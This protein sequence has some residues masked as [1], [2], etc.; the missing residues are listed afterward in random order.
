MTDRERWT[1][2]PLL[3]LALGI[4]LKD[5]LSGSVATDRVECKA[6]VCEAVEVV[7]P[8]PGQRVTINAGNIIC[9]SLIATDETGKQ[10]LAAVSSNQDGGV[11]RTY[12]THTGTHA[13][14]GNFK[15]YAGLLFLDARGGGHAGPLFASPVPLQKQDAQPDAA[16][17][18][19]ATGK[20]DG[21]PST[22]AKAAD[23]PAEDAAATPEAQP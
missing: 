13:V 6:V 5:K 14:L 1:V 17:Q 3:F 19:A 4:S 11:L 18:P 10:Q 12:G 20:P 23:A 16:K 8:N 21:A 2:Y 9:R 22:E 15:Q 7:G